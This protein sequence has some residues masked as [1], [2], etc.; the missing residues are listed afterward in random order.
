MTNEDW[1]L[2]S[3]DFDLPPELIA[4]H[5]A[6]RRD[7]SRLLR[8]SQTDGK[9][10]HHQF[11]E[12]LD[13]LP[14]NCCLV[15]NNTRVLPARLLGH[16]AG[17]GEI[18]ALLVTEEFPGTWSALVRKAGR[19]KPGE[20][21]QFFEGKLTARAL[22]RNE[23]GH[24]L[25]EFVE[26]ERLSENL[27]Q[28]GL[29]PLPPYIKRKKPKEEQI[30]QDRERYQTCYASVP[31]AIAA[32][33]AGLHFTPE[34]LNA[35]QNR[36]I[37]IFELTLHVGLGTFTGV[38]DPDLRK[39]HMH[40]EHFQI[41]EEV[42]QELLEMKKQ[43]NPVIAVGTTVVRVLESLAQE[44]FQRFSGWTD[45]FIYP[46]YEF[47]MVD[48]LLTNFHLPKST[49]LMLVSSFSGRTPLLQA[50]SEAIKQRYRFFS[51]GDC[52][53]LLRTPFLWNSE[54]ERVE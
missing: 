5:P 38:E 1:R 49:L 19:I 43:G 2:E 17:G 18:E 16:R 28:F 36:G 52:M 15:L 13:L 8:L 11:P 29:P 25:L 26:A 23:E 39:H 20:R 34:V 45:I 6:S 50:Y 21:L 32:P 35:I 47:Q 27:E 33:T 3:Y 48:G 22:E 51:Y 4:Q 42:L 31:G 14:Q 30:L 46:P 12:I 9:F 40:S 54:T 24:W 44:G 7:A 10:S 41:S 53:L 37:R